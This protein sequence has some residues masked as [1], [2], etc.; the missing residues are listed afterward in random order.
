MM[1]RK[2]T[3]EGTMTEE[4]NLGNNAPQDPRQLDTS[5]LFFLKTRPS[6]CALGGFRFNHQQLGRLDQLAEVVRQQ[7]PQ[8][9][10]A[11]R[12]ERKRGDGDVAV[13]LPGPSSHEG[14]GR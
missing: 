9:P 12:G 13:G 8:S 10:S 7:I 14:G 5:T 1:A 3:E 6:C 2:A 4:G 11:R